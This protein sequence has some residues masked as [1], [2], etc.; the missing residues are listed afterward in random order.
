MAQAWERTLERLPALRTAFQW[1]SGVPLQWVEPSAKLPWR[2]LTLPGD[3]DSAFRDWLSEDRR[4]G[5]PLDA[6]PL[7]RLTLFRLPTHHRL[8]WTFHHILLDGRSMPIVLQT[9]EDEYRALRSDRGAPSSVPASS[10][11]EDGF[12]TFLDWLEQRDLDAD[13]RFWAEYLDGI[14]SAT[15]LFGARLRPVEGELGATETVSLELDPDTTAR[16]RAVA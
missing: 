2:E 16:L 5:I 3:G 9:V 11:R 12:A 10:G 15:P 4:R 8:V 7:L 13:K 6:P 1:S 14:E